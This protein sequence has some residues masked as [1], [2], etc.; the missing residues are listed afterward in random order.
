MGGGMNYGNPLLDAAS[1]PMG[2]A[3]VGVTTD[4]AELLAGY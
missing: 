2:Y 4:V 1:L 3:G